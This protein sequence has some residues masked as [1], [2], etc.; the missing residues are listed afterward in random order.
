MDINPN[1]PVSARHQITI[2]APIET[3]WQLLTDIDQWPTWNS[4][5]SAATLAGP[6]QPGSTFRWKANGTGIFSTLQAVEPHRYLS[7]TGKVIG[8][9]AIHTWALEPLGDTV[10]VTTAESFEGWL[11]QLT[12]DM[13]Q[14]TLDTSLVAWLTDLKRQAEQSRDRS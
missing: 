3:V 6:M 7:W 8:T 2:N 10:V 1:A 4:N 12:K 13:M 9:R 11:V 14:S 5:I